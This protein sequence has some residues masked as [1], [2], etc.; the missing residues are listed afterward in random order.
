MADTTKVKTCPTGQILKGG[1]CIPK[2]KK[3]KSKGY[4]PEGDTY[5]RKTKT[6]TTIISTGKGKEKRHYTAK[7]KSPSRRG[8]KNLA[9]VIALNKSI[10]DSTKYKDLPRLRKKKRKK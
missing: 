1:K 5:D 3:V 9:T 6:H 8:S 4:S 7:A 10:S 2:E